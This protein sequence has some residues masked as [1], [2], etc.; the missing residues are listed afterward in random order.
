VAEPGGSGKGLVDR[1]RVGRRRGRQA[2]PFRGRELVALALQRLEHVPGRTRVE[3]A[4][5]ELV[6]ALGEGVQM[7]VVRREDRRGPSELLRER[8]QELDEAVLVGQGV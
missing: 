8:E 7:L 4:L 3:V 6:P 2:Q 5:A 1:A